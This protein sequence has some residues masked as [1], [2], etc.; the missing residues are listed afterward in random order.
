VLTTDRV[1]DFEGMLGPG[2]FCVDYEES[3]SVFPI[4]IK[5]LPES[6]TNYLLRLEAPCL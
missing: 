1:E 2:D 4:E 5:L 3:I 6:C